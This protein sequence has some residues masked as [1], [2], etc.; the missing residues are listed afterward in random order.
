MGEN[1]IS[2][3]EAVD[4]VAVI[5]ERDGKSAPR[6]GVCFFCRQY[7]TRLEYDH[8]PIPYQFG[9]KLVVPA[10]LTCHD[11]KDRKDLIDW[12]AEA[13][14]EAFEG[15]TPFAALLL[16]KCVKLGLNATVSDAARRTPRDG[17]TLAA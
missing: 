13:I 15:L 8:F 17:S 7:A 1:R 10:C 16:G 4:D 11:L 3:R 5:S 12:P 9:G 6:D 2:L 14:V